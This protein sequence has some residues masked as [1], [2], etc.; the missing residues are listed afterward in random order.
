VLYGLGKSLAANGFAAQNP[1]KRVM[2]NPCT[3]FQ[4]SNSSL[5]NLC[6]DVFAYRYLL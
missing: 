6:P 4:L 3:P 1:F 2:T 5:E